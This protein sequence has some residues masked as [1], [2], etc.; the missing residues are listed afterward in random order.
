MDKR[1]G[2]NIQ[3]EDPNKV[4]GKNYKTIA[5]LAPLYEY[6]TFKAQHIDK[7]SAVEMQTLK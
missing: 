2:G 6:S 4:K 3:I 7:I 5:R 1:W